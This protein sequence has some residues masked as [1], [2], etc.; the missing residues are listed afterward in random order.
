ML[1]AS[2][3]IICKL[4]KTFNVSF[5]KAKKERKY[6]EKL[7]AFKLWKETTDAKISTLIEPKFALNYIR[8][9]W[10]LLF[11]LRIIST[12][13]SFSCILYI[14]RSNRDRISPNPE[15]YVL[16]REFKFWFLHRRSRILFSSRLVDNLTN[17]FSATCFLNDGNRMRTGTMRRDPAM[18]GCFDETSS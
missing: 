17:A 11:S 4:L 9:L 10:A 5:E 6:S 1:I 14:V 2:S 16:K 3:M 18:F 13:C 8:Q 7:S 15:T 12:M